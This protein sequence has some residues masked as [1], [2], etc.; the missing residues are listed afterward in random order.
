MEQR[1]AIKAGK[2]CLAWNQLIHGIRGLQG[3]GVKL[4]RRLMCVPW[5]IFLRRCY[6]CSSC[7]RKYPALLQPLRLDSPSDDRPVLLMLL[8]LLLLLMS[9]ASSPYSVA[10][11]RQKQQA[12]QSHTIG[13]HC[14]VATRHVNAASSFHYDREPAALHTR[15]CA[16]SVPYI[17]HTRT[18]TRFKS[19]SHRFC[20]SVLRFG[21]LYRLAQLPGAGTCA[22]RVDATTSDHAL[23]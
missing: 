10:P 6:L 21:Q 8:L 11:G 7:L 19:L 3:R 18:G 14:S 9:T 13:R 22:T 15:C 16:S 17:S 5:T 20:R 1:E 23:P 12:K 4:T 2:R